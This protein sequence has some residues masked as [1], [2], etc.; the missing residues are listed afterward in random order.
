MIFVVEDEHSAVGGNRDRIFC[1]HKSKLSCGC[2]VRYQKKHSQNGQIKHLRISLATVERI[3]CAF[4][5]TIC[6][7]NHFGF[8][9]DFSRP[10]Y[11]VS[12]NQN[13]GQL[14]RKNPGG[15]ALFWGVP[16]LPPVFPQSIQG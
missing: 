16:P 2:Q 8:W 1:D 11:D 7:D 6:D 3:V 15:N 5:R 9:E 14:S 4:I 12:W 13:T 10:S